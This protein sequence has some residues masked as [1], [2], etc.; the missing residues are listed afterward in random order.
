MSFREHFDQ[1]CRD[2]GKE[3]G[4]KLVYSEILD[5]AE[6]S[7]QFCMGEPAK[8][9]RKAQ[10]KADLTE[11]EWI[12]SLEKDEALKGVNVRGEISRCALWYKQN[13]S[14][15]GAPTRRRITNWL[16]KA[17]R[18]VSL[19]SQGAAHATG[20]KLP[21]PQGPE[22]WLEWVKTELALISQDHPAHG[23]VLYAYN[24]RQWTALPKSWQARCEAGLVGSHLA[25]LPR[26]EDERQRFRHA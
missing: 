12:S 14:T 7:H 26:E 16:L 8:T 15:A 9:P 1:A 2:K 3:L 21:A 18:V 13:V 25:A 22:G 10:K 23:V 24:C 17:E 6:S 19:K 5:L 20:L 11:E 4:R